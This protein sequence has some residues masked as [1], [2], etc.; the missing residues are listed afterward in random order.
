MAKTPDPTKDPQFQQVVQTFLRT[1]PKP[2]AK[3]ADK[4]KTARKRKAAGSKG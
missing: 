4:R 3:K 2:H 1:P